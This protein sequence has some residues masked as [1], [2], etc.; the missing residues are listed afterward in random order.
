MQG[1]EP[2]LSSHYRRIELAA[3]GVAG[4]LRHTASVEMQSQKL[5]CFFFFLCFI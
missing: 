3:L 4:R 1:N 2:D 5:P